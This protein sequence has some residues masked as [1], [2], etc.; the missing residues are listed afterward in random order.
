MST[1]I[2]IDIGGTGI[3][4]APVDLK[5]GNLLAPRFR[6]LTPEPR[7]PEV[8][9]KTIQSML[10]QTGWEG[11][12]G[13]GFPGIIK[14]G[15]CGSATNMNPSWVGM[16]MVQFFSDGLKRDVI[17][18]NDADAAGVAEYHYGSLDL[19]AYQVV[20]FLTIGTG[21][22]S[23]LLHKGELLPNTELGH[24]KW[25]KGILEEYA[26][27][28]AREVQELS[29]KKWGARLNKALL[30]IN[31]VMAPEVIVLGGGVSK[32]FDLFK[33]HLH[34]DIPIVPASLKN[35]A[36]VIGAAQLTTL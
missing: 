24:L 18:C 12:I 11:R 34:L 1:A 7:S 4:M 35:E 9:L 13:I 14:S 21:I 29:W 5:T 27:N 8:I 28:K 2:G 33:D 3:K 17:I 23:A 31:H 26:S 19:S 25:R 32:K 22:G 36:G 30:Y 20:L 10:Q 6:Q 16:D 15:I